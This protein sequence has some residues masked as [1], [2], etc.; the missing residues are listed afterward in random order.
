M[1]P[2]AAARQRLESIRERTRSARGARR[3][4]EQVLEAARQDGDQDAIGIA[5]LALQEARHEVEVADR[6]ESMLLAQLS[7]L[8]G[9]GLDG[10]F[11][12]DPEALRSLELLA[13]TSTPIGNVVL[14]RYA[15]A[16]QFAASL[17]RGVRA[18]SGGARGGSDVVVPASA[19]QEA[20]YGIV[21]QLYQPLDLLDLLPTATMTGAAFSYVIE[22]GPLDEGAAETVEGEVKPEGQV[23]FDEDEVRAVTVASW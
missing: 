6:L 16:E 22:G 14:G 2:S 13:H 12:D 20:P 3:R 9:H 18:E 10:G 15:T 17:G 4:S 11:L 5:E 1:T 19:R 23:E 21:R 7:G 8:N